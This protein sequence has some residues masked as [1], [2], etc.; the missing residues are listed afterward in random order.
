MIRTGMI[1][2][3]VVLLASRGLFA[4]SE[5]RPNVVLILGQHGGGVSKEPIAHDGSKPAGQLYNLA[6]DLAESENLYDAK[7]GKV[8]ELKELLRRIQVD[9]RSRP[10]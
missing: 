3:V 2:V 6:S 7:P 4:V 10:K 9:G 8:R 5:D 1:A